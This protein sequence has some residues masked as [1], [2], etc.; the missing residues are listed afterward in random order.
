MTSSTAASPFS[1]VGL[2]PEE[3]EKNE[4][5]A[6]TNKE[7]FLLKEAQEAHTAYENRDY[8]ASVM[9]YAKCLEEAI[10]KNNG[11]Q[12]APSTGPLYL[13][14]GKALLQLAIVNQSL[15]IVNEAAVDYNLESDSTHKLIELDE[16][17]YEDS[18]QEEGQDEEDEVEDKNADEEEEESGDDFA[19]AWEVLDIARFIFSKQDNN[20]LQE[21][22]ALQEMGDLSMET[23]NFGTAVSDYKKA[24]EILDKIDA[25]LRERASLHFKIGIAL[26]FEGTDWLAAKTSYQKA[27]ELLVKSLA[28]KEASEKEEVKDDISLPDKEKDDDADLKELKSLI[29]EVE[30][31]MLE[32]ENGGGTAAS[33]KDI[34]MDAAKSASTTTAAQVNDLSSLVKKR[35]APTGEEDDLSKHAK[36]D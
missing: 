28:E 31:K 24:V 11:D 22:E 8:E 7:Q 4:Q 20:K 1:N 12:V 10:Q 3:H 19:L 23:E 26:E 6:V 33:L 17:E 27:K 13:A 18:S 32:L 15:G 16:Y 34:L 25:S 36:N 2:T 30:A 5:L 14:Y 21:A 35:K 9:L 29:A